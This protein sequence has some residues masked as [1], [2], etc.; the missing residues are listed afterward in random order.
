MN[1]VSVIIPTYNRAE[2]VMGSIESALAQTRPPDEII[3]IDDG[4][5]DDTPSVLTQAPAGVRCIRQDN[6]GVSEARNRGVREASGRWIAFLDSDDRWYPEKLEVQLAAL[7]AGGADWSISN[8]H[9]APDLQRVADRPPESFEAAFPLVADT[10]RSAGYWF[11]DHLEHRAVETAHGA[12]ET[13]VGDLFPVLLRG[14]L[15]QP[16][17]MMIDRALFE[18]AGAFDPGRRVA[19][20]TDFGLRLSATGAPC[21]AVMRP[22][23]LWVIGEYDSLTSSHNTSQLIRNALES[24]DRA[25]A[26]RGGV[27]N[28]EE[29]EAL[30]WGRKTLHRRLAY[31]LL[32]DLERRDARRVAAEHVLEGGLPDPVLAGIWLSSFLPD[33]ALDLARRVKSRRL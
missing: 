2:W 3:V 28:P 29:L 5:T 1:S 8:G 21:V 30:A 25:V 23:Y 16:T 22:L 14:N 9:L 17:G 11:T 18:R 31:T 20:D 27:L 4:S 13:F 26:L 12:V 24:L 10:G 15:V 7:A 6:A 32:S 19:G 33:S